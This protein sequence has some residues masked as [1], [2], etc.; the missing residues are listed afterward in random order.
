MQPLILNAPTYVT[1]GPF[2]GI[3]GNL[4]ENNPDSLSVVIAKANSTMQVLRRS[5]S[6]SPLSL[7]E[8]RVS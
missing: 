8:G 4:V 5:V 7:S 1:E 3:S 6:Q 2:K